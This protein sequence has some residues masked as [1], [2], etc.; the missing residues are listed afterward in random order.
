MAPRLNAQFD[1]EVLDLEVETPFSFTTGQVDH[2]LNVGGGYRLKRF[3]FSYLAGGFDSLYTENHFK[4]FFN[5]QIAVGPFGAVASLRADLHPLIPITQTI[6]PR[7]A[8]LFRIFDKTSIRATAG[9]AYR[10]PNGVESYMLLNLPTP[11][12]GVFIE[13]FGN[14]DLRP[15]RINTFELGI[16]DESSFLHTAD[17]VVYLN[18]VTDLISLSDV[19]PGINPFD[20][21][22]NGV[23]VG[24][25]GWINLDPTY[26]GLG[27]EAEVE[28]YPTDGLDVFANANVMRVVENNAGDVIRDGSASTLKLNG[29]L[30]YRTPY[31]FD[32]SLTAHYLSAQEWRLRQFDPDT[33][34]IATAPTPIDAR[35]MISARVA[36]RPIPD[37]DLEL[38]ATIWNATQLGPE[39][40]VLE[41]P[42]GQ[43][44]IGRAYATLSYRF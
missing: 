10:A 8:L 18:Q 23:E 11:S 12:D 15:E 20:P 42:E 24:E 3:R 25:T 32:L 37:Q 30:S 43:P 4:G 27:L 7:G 17:V 39:A 21:V 13:D 44:V 33:L 38:A 40:G 34:A 31:R 2:T 5:E 9:S 1:N 41:H 36:V 22:S 35:T 28:L 14:Q 16:H 19:T 26:T 29:G 6:S